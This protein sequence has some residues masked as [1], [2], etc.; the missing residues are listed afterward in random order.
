MQFEVV[1]FVVIAYFHQQILALFAEIN[2]NL[3]VFAA[4]A[5]VEKFI[6]LSMIPALLET[7]AFTSQP[8]FGKRIIA[9]LHGNIVFFQ[10]RVE[11]FFHITAFMA[12][13]FSRNIEI[14]GSLKI[15]VVSSHAFLLLDRVHKYCGW[16]IG[17][18][19]IMLSY[20][21]Y[22][23]EVAPF[24]WQSEGVADLE[25]VHNFYGGVAGDVAVVSEVGKIF[26]EEQG[27]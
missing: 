6:W 23:V 26:I 8:Q 16:V 1:I 10:D 7:A 5:K 11:Y 12:D 20:E 2:E 24:D 25:L 17:D 9:I 27:L 13:N 19:C 18:G 3:A 15:D 22:V 4:N 21:I 14:V